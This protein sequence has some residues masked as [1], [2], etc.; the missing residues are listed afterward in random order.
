MSISTRNVI[1]V[2][3]ICDIAFN[4]LVSRV[5]VLVMRFLMLKYDTYVVGSVVK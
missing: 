3:Y 5:S 4:V 1:L 2:R